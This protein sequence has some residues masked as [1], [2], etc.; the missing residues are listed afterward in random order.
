MVLVESPLYSRGAHKGSM[1]QVI[2]GSLFFEGH[3]LTYYEFFEMEDT[4]PRIFIFLNYSSASIV[5]KKRR[6][7]Q[8][9]RRGKACATNVRGVKKAL[10]DRNLSFQSSMSFRSSETTKMVEYDVQ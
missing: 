1:T 8:F 9:F 6:E 2:S 3:I 10:L 7:L 5:F 4:L